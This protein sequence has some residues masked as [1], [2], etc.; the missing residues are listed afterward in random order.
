MDNN[1]WQD[2]ENMLKRIE[3][4]SKERRDKP[5]DFFCDFLSSIWMDNTPEEALVQWKVK[6]EQFPWYAD[7]ALYCINAVIDNP[8]DNLVALM[9]E[10]GWLYLC[11]E[12]TP[13][14]TPFTYDEY[15]EWLKQLSKQYQEIYDSAPKEI[16]NK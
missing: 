10:H 1:D 15:L 16:D 8:P 11:H 6:V 13:E 12:D 2:G 9:D 5:L 4:K 3:K 7:D 14:E